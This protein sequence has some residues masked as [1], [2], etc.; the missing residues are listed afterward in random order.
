ME[1]RSQQVRGR[2][3]KREKGGGLGGLGSRKTHTFRGMPP[4]SWNS[5]PYAVAADL[6]KEQGGPLAPRTSLSLPTSGWRGRVMSR[7]PLQR[8]LPGTSGQVLSGCQ[9]WLC[10]M[11]SS[12]HTAAAAAKET[13]GDSQVF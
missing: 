8:S 9:M 11:A 2:Q 6:Q 3:A 5:P 4:T 7:G 13:V 1:G 10:L 12:F